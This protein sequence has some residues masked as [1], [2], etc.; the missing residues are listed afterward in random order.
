MP[1]RLAPT[2]RSSSRSSKR[3]EPATPATE[4]VVAVGEIV[5]AHALKGLLRV[6]AYQPPAPSL[7]PGRQI[8]VEHG[9]TS[10]Q[11]TVVSAA[12]HAGEWF[13]QEFKMLVR[14][15]FPKLQPLAS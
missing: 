4:G 12:P 14:N 13:P 2:G 6:R 10:R 15:A 5:A 1:P 7:A 9:D 3:N 8:V 11:A